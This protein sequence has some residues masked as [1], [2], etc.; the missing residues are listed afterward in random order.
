MRNATHVGTLMMAG[1]LLGCGDHGVGSK[2]VGPECEPGVEVV[3]DD[4]ASGVTDQA[5]VPEVDPRQEQGQPATQPPSEREQ[6]PD[7]DPVEEPSTEDPADP[8]TVDTPPDEGEEGFVFE[9]DL[10]AQENQEI[11]TLRGAIFDGLDLGRDLYVDTLE[12]VLQGYNVEVSWPA[13][14]E[15]PTSEEDEAAAECPFVAAYANGFEPDPMT[16]EYLADLAK[17]EA[18]SKLVDTLEDAGPMDI[19][20]LSLEPEAVFWRE[21][22]LISGI[23]EQRVVRR[24]DMSIGQMCN[25]EPTPVEN[26]KIHGLKKGKDLFIEVFNEW[27]AANGYVADYPIMSSK[28]QVCNVNVA[29]L[30]PAHKQ[31]Q[32]AVPG[33]VEVNPLCLNY[34]PPS[35][36]EQLQ[37]GQAEIEYEQGVSQGVDDEFAKAAV[38]VFT[39]VPCNVS[40]PVVVDLDRDGFELL[41]VH[42]GVNFDLYGAG[43]VQAVAWVGADDGLLALDRNENGRI[44]DGGELFGNIDRGFADGFAHLTS[45]DDNGDGVLDAADA[46]FG[47]LVVWRDADTDGVSTPDE[48]IAIGSVGITAIPLSPMELDLRLAGNRIPL[49]VQ[50]DAVDGP[51]AVGDAL[52][53]T[54]PWPRV[55]R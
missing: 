27:L 31:A 55:I 1:L 18:Y 26:S 20:P 10:T 36:L 24:G 23:E 54:A 46:R 32:D 53:R 39:V 35:Q 42:E 30:E 45:L 22:G 43:R 2:C 9:E 51:I 21:Q 15:N 38:S 34:E 28:I 13:S 16:C 12:V 8:G 40:D 33:F 17:V 29:M 47:D 19:E 4:S 44:D 6:T 14:E 50:A 5:P 41:G 7:P 37:F 49:A 52:L 11:Q 3:V 48:L 25:K